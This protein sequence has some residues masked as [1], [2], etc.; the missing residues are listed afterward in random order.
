MQLSPSSNNALCGL[1]PTVGLTSRHLVIP[2]SQTQDTIG[3]MAKDCK[4]VAAML[5]VIAGK[6]PLDNYTSAIPFD[7]I[8]DYAASCTADGLKGARIGKQ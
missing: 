7:T 1:K 5:S 3:P 4:T 8:P 6:D 2:V